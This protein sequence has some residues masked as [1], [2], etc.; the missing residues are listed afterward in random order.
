MGGWP[1]HEAREVPWRQVFRSGTRED[2]MLRTVRAALPPRIADAE[3]TLN[4]RSMAAME[5]ATREMTA[6][7]HDRGADLAALRTT[8]L[9]T[10]SVASSKIERIEASSDDYARALHGNRSNTAATSMAAATTAIDVLITSAARQPITLDSLL[11][12]HAA[13]MREDIRERAYAGRLRDMQNWIG[14][15][16][17]SPRHAAY[18][19]PPPDLVPDYMDDLIA[20]CDRTD[21]PAVAQAALAHAQFESIH[22]FTDGNGRIGRALINA[23]LRR[24]GVTRQVVIPIA[25]ALVAH[26]DRYFALLDDYRDGHADHVIDAFSEAARIAASGSRETAERLRRLPDA[27]RAAVSPLRR[28]SATDRLLSWVPHVA[29][30]T[31]EEAHEEIGGPLSSVYTS[32]E[33]LVGASILR[34]L[35][36]RKRNQVWGVADVLDELDDLGARI[37]RTATGPDT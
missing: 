31:A 8:L 25:S 33:R 24:R 4:G 6:L 2:R 12:A 19:P 27:W 34:P 17:H 26:R 1:R 21:L 13:L 35:T 20:F 30:F 32:I 11:R 14:G 36:D 37:A 23:V 28:G 7:D 15:S 3:L 16:D 5:T 9:R 18:V 22:P 29:A 10:E